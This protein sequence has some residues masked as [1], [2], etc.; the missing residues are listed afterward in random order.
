M[1]LER[2]SDDVLLKVSIAI[3][4]TMTKRN[5]GK[6]EFVSSYNSKVRENH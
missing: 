1:K 2:K 4:N 6:K 5:F 3:I